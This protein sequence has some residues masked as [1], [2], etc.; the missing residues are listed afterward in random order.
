MNIEKQLRAIEKKTNEA[1]EKVVK[2][3][4]NELF[5]RTILRSPVRDG[6]FK[7]NWLAGY[8][9]APDTFYSTDR[10]SIGLM[11]MKL[12]EFDINAQFYFTN[13]LPYAQRLEYGYS[14]QAPNGM[15]RLGKA[16]FP[17]IAQEQIN[18][19]KF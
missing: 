4:Y 7:S 5:N 3:S 16:E 17:Q 14:D 1:L 12:N 18:K 11:K 13:S 6:Y 10:D 8:S 19:Y 2:G 15:V 9:F